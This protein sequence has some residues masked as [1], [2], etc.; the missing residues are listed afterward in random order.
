MINLFAG[1]R[2]AIVGS[3][4]YPHFDHVFA[5]VDQLPPD[6]IVITGGAKGPDTWAEQR[7]RKRGLQG[8]VHR[9]H[10]KVGLLHDPLAG[11]KRNSVVVADSDVVVA[12]W[13]GKSTGTA[14]TIRKAANEKRSVL[15]IGLDGRV[16][17]RARPVAEQTEIPTGDPFEGVDASDSHASNGV[18]TPKSD[19]YTPNLVDGEPCD[20]PGC[21]SH[22]SHPCEGCGRIGGRPV[23]VCSSCGSSSFENNC[24]SCGLPPFEELG[25]DPRC[26]VGHPL[27]PDER[28]AGLCLVCE[29]EKD[30]PFEGER[31]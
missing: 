8:V 11:F 6:A 17:P 4:D 14:D 7:A 26:P 22:V 31:W 12:F 2:V 30:D 16:M 25:T 3:R 28:R 10:W 18:D 27:E 24:N 13:D 9:A 29:R 19:A 15:I 5:F 1:A 23:V 20:H 21:L